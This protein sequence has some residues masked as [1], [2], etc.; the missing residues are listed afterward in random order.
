MTAGGAMLVKNVITST[1]MAFRQ[2]NLVGYIR[3]SCPQIVTTMPH[4]NNTVSQCDKLQTH[5][6]QYYFKLI[7][8]PF[9]T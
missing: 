6:W 3:I 1:G 8:Q 7:L 4:K 2:H 9:L 5:T